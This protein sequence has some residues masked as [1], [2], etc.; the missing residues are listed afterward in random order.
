MSYTPIDVETA[1]AR[2]QDGWAP[3]VLDVRN[4]AEV[5]I[6]RFDFMDRLH[7]YERVLEI[8]H[9]L[10]RDR[11]ILLT[12]RSGGRSAMA[13]MMLAGEGFTRLFNLEGGIND[14]AKK[15]DPSLRVY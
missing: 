11:D 2:M 3:Y 9:D 12:C 15:V 1:R 7:P 10:P 8:A 6:S 13:A 4:D 14:W 5:A